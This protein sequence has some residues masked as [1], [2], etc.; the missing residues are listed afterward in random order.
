[1]KIPKYIQDMLDG[2]RI[3]QAPLGEQAKVYDTGQGEYGFMFRIYR[4]NNSQH[5]MTFTAEVNRVMVW[6][7]REYA[8]VQ[9]HHY[10]WF[11]DKEHRKPYY[12]RD[13]ALVTI[14]DP[15]ARQFEKAM[16]LAKD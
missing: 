11:T 16:E 10:C 7:Q 9:F 8:H 13:Y 5:S 12:K 1:M 14:N 15:V 4:R 3:R 2:G 6:A